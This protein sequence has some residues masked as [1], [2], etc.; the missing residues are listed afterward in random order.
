MSELESQFVKRGLW[1]NRDEGPV[2]GKT[3]TTDSRSGAI[4]IVLLAIL[5]SLGTAHFWHIF[6]FMIYQLRANGRPSDALFRQQQVILRTLP[7]P[8]SLIADSIKFFWTWRIELGASYALMRNLALALLALSF[9]LISWTA[10]IFSSYVVTS[11]NLQVLVSSPSCGRINLTYDSVDYITRNYI[12]RFSKIAEPFAEDCILSE[13]PTPRARCNTL[14]QP[15]TLFQKERTECPFS[16]SMCLVN[17]TP[18]IRFDSGLINVNWLG[19]NLDPRD[20]VLF[21]KQTTCAP[22]TLENRTTIMNATDYPNFN[23]RAFPQEEILLVSYGETRRAIGTTDEYTFG[24]SLT[25]SNRSTSYTTT[26]AIGASTREWQDV[27]DFDPLPEMRRDDADIILRSVEQG[28]VG[29]REPVDDPVFAAH[30]DAHGSTD[31]GP[32]GFVFLPDFPIAMI[33][34]AQ[35]YQ[36]CFA[37]AGLPDH[38]TNLSGLPAIPTRENLPSANEIQLAIIQNLVTASALYDIATPITYNIS[39]FEYQRVNRPIPNNHWEY[40]LE[41]WEAIA[42]AGINIILTDYAIGAKQ[43]DPEADAYTVAPTTE[44]EKQLCN[45]QKMKKTGDFVNINVFGLVFIITFACVVVIVDLMLLKV[46]IYLSIFQR[47]TG[48]SSRLQRW[49]QD[50]VF[51][52]QRRAYEAE[53]QGTWTNL[54]EDVPITEQKELLEDLA[55]QSV[56]PPASSNE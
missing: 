8:G 41:R 22:L 38:C 31:H 19:I 1:T 4:I 47:A 33:G 9:L 40:E 48:L 44:G 17:T 29:Y 27:D 21:R 14:I 15:K 56:K 51:Q 53:G 30:R 10:S 28:I 45:A 54:N 50:G 42:W 16:E 49:I 2:M 13:S 25:Q 5:S 43:R 18:A 55:L 26:V 46:L 36:Y 3:I 11:T 37:Q 12:D 7:T 20:R 39:K 52:L 6:A 35:Q 34:C 32:K 24:V 23:M